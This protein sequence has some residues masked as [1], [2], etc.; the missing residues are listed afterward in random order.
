MDMLSVLDHA[1]RGERAGINYLLE[2]LDGQ[3]LVQK[4]MGPGATSNLNWTEQLTKWAVQ[5]SPPRLRIENLLYYNRLLDKT[6]FK[7]S[8]L[9]R[10]RVPG[11]WM[12]PRRWST[13]R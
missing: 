1:M 13:N 10:Q 8:D 6:N 9:R 7:C 11:K 4:L 5:L 12:P 2:T 3:Q